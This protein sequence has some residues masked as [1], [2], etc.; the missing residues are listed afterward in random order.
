MCVR[1]CVCVCAFSVLEDGEAKDGEEAGEEDEEEEG[2]ESSSDEDEDDVPSQGPHNDQPICVTARHLLCSPLLVFHVRP[3][4]TTLCRSSVFLFCLIIAPW[5]FALSGESVEGVHAPA[6]INAPIEPRLFV[7][8]GE[9][10]GEELLRQ[11]DVDE[12]RRALSVLES[13]TATGDSNRQVFAIPP[14]VPRI[15]I[16]A[17]EDDENIGLMRNGKRSASQDT[18]MSRRSR[19]GKSKKKG[20]IKNGKNNNMDEQ[21]GPTDTSAAQ[22]AFALD[23]RLAP[24]ATST[25]PMV[26]VVTCDLTA[27]QTS[28]QK[29]QGLDRGPEPGLPLTLKK[30]ADRVL[31]AR[32]AILVR[33]LVEVPAQS[34]AATRAVTVAETRC[35]KWRDDRD[36]NQDRFD[37]DDPREKTA[38]EA[39]RSLVESI[40]AIRAKQARA[41]DCEPDEANLKKPSSR[42]SLRKA[43]RSQSSNASNDDGDGEARPEATA[44]ATGDG[45]NITGS[46]AAAAQPGQV[47]MDNNMQYEDSSMKFGAQ[48]QQKEEEWLAEQQALQGGGEERVMPGA[49]PLPANGRQPLL[50]YGSSANSGQLEGMPEDVRQAHGIGGFWKDEAGSSVFRGD[51][52]RSNLATAALPGATAVDSGLSHEELQQQVDADN[53]VPNTISGK[54]LVCADLSSSFSSFHHCTHFD[55]RLTI[56]HSSLSYTVYLLCNAHV[57]QTHRGGR[58]TRGH[59]SS[60]VWPQHDS[61]PAGQLDAFFVA[62]GQW[63]PPAA[64]GQ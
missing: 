44:A 14:S 64:V 4:L 51:E 18:T 59:V 30:R 5:S 53:A 3:K 29:A 55:T 6:S 17:Q 43:R 40:R 54:P 47:G 42:A 32:R 34:L 46:E 9:G 36:S 13:R 11:S 25:K 62:A 2:D 23:G 35:D 63:T 10:G 26:H 20:K 22:V 1:A 37:V 39:E 19:R 60:W 8:D 15:E 45:G 41:K 58:R 56:T 48:Q 50:R 52:D 57:A 61:W 49:S 31:E 16:F 38:I 12:Y 7:L 27:R 21:D 24:A 33:R 28:L